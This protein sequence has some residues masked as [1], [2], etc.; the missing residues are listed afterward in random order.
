MAEERAFEDLLKI[1]ERPAL[2]SIRWSS[3]SRK[4][5]DLLADMEVC[6]AAAF[7]ERAFKEGELAP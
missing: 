2:A 4:T 1:G 5:M 7:L 6:L 3:E